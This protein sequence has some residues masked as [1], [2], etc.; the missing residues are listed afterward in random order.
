MLGIERFMASAMSVVRIVPDAPTIMPPTIRATLSSAMPAAAAESPVR[1]FS[2]EMTTG[3]S[4]PPMGSTTMLPSTAAATRIRMNRPSLS[5]PAAMATAAPTATVSRARFTSC[6]PGRTIGLPGISSC[7]LP[8]AMLEPQKEIEPTMA[9][10]R[11]GTSVSS[12][13]LPPRSSAS[14]YST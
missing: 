5:E 12:S 9:A 13:G 8:K 2:R 4:A 7:S 11:I 3:M 10:N 6:W 14:R 1:A